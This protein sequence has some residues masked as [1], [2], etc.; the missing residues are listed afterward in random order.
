MA[1][2]Q[3]MERQ[4]NSLELQLENEKHSHERT[5][6]KTS[7]QATQITNLSSKIEELQNELAR[8]QRAQQQ[9]GRDPQQNAG[10]EKER[11]VL[12]GKIETLRW[13]NTT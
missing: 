7:E 3:A 1:E 11:L 13:R 2:K 9:R 4:L 5:R 8:E 6:T 12:E 10:W